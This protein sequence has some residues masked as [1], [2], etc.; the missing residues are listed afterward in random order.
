LINLILDQIQGP[1]GKIDS[2][3]LEK[4]VVQSPESREKLKQALV[5]CGLELSKD[6]IWD[7]LLA[8]M[9]KESKGHVDTLILHYSNIIKITYPIFEKTLKRGLDIARRI[10]NAE[11]IL[12]NFDKFC[13]GIQEIYEECK[14]ITVTTLLN[15]E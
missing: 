3:R 13:S 11:A 2:E 6:K 5:D 14:P 15:H 10:E 9:I 7:T 1:N 8:D 4:F 12:P